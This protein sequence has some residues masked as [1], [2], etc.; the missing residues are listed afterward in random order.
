MSDKVIGKRGLVERPFRC[1][2]FKS[3][4]S[5][6]SGVRDLPWPQPHFE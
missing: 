5:G 4:R 2:G 1:G 3:R 6:T